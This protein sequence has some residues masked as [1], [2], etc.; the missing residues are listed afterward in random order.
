M[1]KRVRPIAAARRK[2]LVIQRNPPH[3]P[4]LPELVLIIFSSLTLPEIR[5]MMAVQHQWA[6]LANRHAVA[7]LTEHPFLSEDVRIMARELCPVSD[8]ELKRVRE[9]GLLVVFGEPWYTYVNYLTRINDFDKDA[10]G[11][12]GFPSAQFVLKSLPYLPIDMASWLAR[13]Y[14]ADELV[15]T[16]FDVM[17]IFDYLK[18]GE[19]STIICG[20]AHHLDRLL[21]L[22]RDPAKREELRAWFDLLGF[23]IPARADFRV[24]PFLSSTRELFEEAFFHQDRA[25]HLREFADGHTFRL[26]EKTM[27]TFFTAL[28]GKEPL[29]KKN[30]P[31]LR[32]L[33]VLCHAQLRSKGWV[34]QSVR[35]TL[36]RLCDV[37]HIRAG[38]NKEQLAL[39]RELIG[40]MWLSS[41]GLLS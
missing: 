30:M 34:Y 7:L 20:I 19:I 8:N 15:S 27:V 9:G 36:P 16:D 22:H 38:Q 2:P 35:D 12:G 39:W 14:L 23:I 31:L 40:C 1:S 29:Q 32:Q 6:D 33:A 28:V 41:T 26:L 21:P 11:S 17:D 13:N 4:L 24:A 5:V 10:P 3:E 37:I 18:E 25:A